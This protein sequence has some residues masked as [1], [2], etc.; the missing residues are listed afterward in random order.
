MFGG[1]NHKKCTKII[2][3][4]AE[5][6]NI[7]LPIKEKY[8]K[9][10]FHIYVTVQKVD[11]LQPF[12]RLP[13]FQVTGSGFL[14][15]GNKII[16]NAH[17]VENAKSIWG[18]LPQYGNY[19][20]NLVVEC[21]CLEKDLA[22]LRVGDKDLDKIKDLVPLPIAD[23]LAIQSTADVLTMGYPLGNTK[24]QVTPGI[25]SGMY[26]TKYPSIY[27]DK[28][29]N[30]IVSTAALN[31]GQS[32]SALL[33]RSGKVVGINSAIV[34]NAQSVGYVIPSRTLLTYLHA[35]R[36]ITTKTT[37]SSTS[38]YHPLTIGLMYS[39][40]N[41]DFFRN[42]RVSPAGILITEIY[43]WS[44]FY[45]YIV[46]GDI[47]VSIT[48]TD[49]HTG[50]NV[51]AEFDRYGKIS[52]CAF[53]DEYQKITFY[54][55]CEYWYPGQKLSLRIFRDSKEQTIKIEDLR[56]LPKPSQQIEDCSIVYRIISGVCI[57][58]IYDKMDFPESSA[59][60]EY[61]NYFL[62]QCL[63][64]ENS[65]HNWY[66]ISHIF[67]NTQ[68]FNDQCLNQFSIIRSINN[69]KLR[70]LSDLDNAIKKVG[71]DLTFQTYDKRY[72]VIRRSTA[73][74]ID[75][76]L[77]KSFKGSIDKHIFPILH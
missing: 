23:S 55:L 47:I 66:M 4:K 49:F 59:A 28:Y 57:L 63:E 56:C 29:K 22:T 33:N 20:I 15:E 77:Y 5:R 17:V 11:V 73:I 71:E 7:W 24:V 75:D 18:R 31:K 46:E 50:K 70:K 52:S 37:T 25:I 1:G 32:G 54:Q 40:L 41:E 61:N 43:S 53:S 48:F 8:E 34:R 67:P 72:Y 27:P 9:S 19:N 68:T 14:I 60:F 76:E 3:E 13:T 12:S 26:S 64:G 44:M 58:Q 36:D 51:T 69:I 65:N 45:N 35:T 10:A 38:Y 6:A 21:I 74:K 30:Y 42:D 16:S 39:P 2:E 62:P